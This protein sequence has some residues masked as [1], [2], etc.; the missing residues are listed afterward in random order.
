M[1]MRSF[2]PVVAL[3]LGVTLASAP[4]ALA[5][6]EGHNHGA[7]AGPAVSL[8]DVAARA[9]AVGSNFQ[10]VA[11]PKLGQ[12]V[13]FLDSTETNAPVTGARIEIFAG[14]ATVTAEESAPGLYVVS[15][16]PAEGLSEEDAETV[17]LVATV[18]LGE[19]EEV[20][21][22]HMA[23]LV[24]GDHAGHDHGA[25]GEKPGDRV[26]LWEGVRPFAL[27]AAAGLVALFGAFAGL[28]STGRRRWI[29]LAVTGI[30]IVT[31]I[32]TTGLV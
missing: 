17:E 14:D 12:L 13:I 9:A 29:G 5:Q 22:A 16:W 27:P 32:A 10:F 20:L 23:G 21:L 15:P 2:L 24:E 1:D 18:I 25:G 3:T 19:Q 6:H 28:R 26:A 30:G 11:L 31:M 4:A 8:Q 7:P